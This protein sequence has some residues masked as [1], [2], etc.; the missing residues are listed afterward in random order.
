MKHVNQNTQDIVNASTAIGAAMSNFFALREERAAWAH[1]GLPVRGADLAAHRQAPRLVKVQELALR[2]LT[3]KAARQRRI[4]MSKANSAKI[5]RTVHAEVRAIDA[6][7]GAERIYRAS[8]TVKGQ[9]AQAK[10]MKAAAA[11]IKNQRPYMLLEPI[12][13]Q[14]VS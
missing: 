6:I 13:F 14:I 4:P 8:V 11:Q 12:R 3:P 9:N 7:T 1:A 2:H 5:I 10:A